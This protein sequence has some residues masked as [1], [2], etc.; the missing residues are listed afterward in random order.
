MQ[1]EMDKIRLLELIRAEYAFVERTLAALTPDDMLIPDVQGWW[2]V[3]DT[4]AHLTA[5]LERVLMWFDQAGHGQNP[6]IPD[7][8]YD[9]KD[10][11]KMNDACSAR[12]KDLP[13]AT[14]RSNF[15]R[16]HLEVCELVEALS[17]RDLFEWDWDGAF[18]QA[19][20]RLITG[21]TYEHLHEHIVP[22][23]QWI[24]QRER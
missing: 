23:R 5:W 6:D 24:D 15:Q 20:W 13:L 4:I 1:P 17:E 10:I 9:W 14:V 7:K 8:G 3:K 11:D 12:D 22:I 19:P 16:V 18:Y 21:N 2:S